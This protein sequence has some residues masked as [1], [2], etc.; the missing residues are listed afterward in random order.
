[1]EFAKELKRKGA[2]ELSKERAQW[3]EAKAKREGPVDVKTTAQ[4][5]G[6]SDLTGWVEEEFDSD[7]QSSTPYTIR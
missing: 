2:I 6:R 4:P 5:D 3:E 7:S 1:M